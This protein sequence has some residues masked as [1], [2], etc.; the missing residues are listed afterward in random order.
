M[1]DV[2]YPRPASFITATLIAAL[3]VAL[4]ATVIGT[5]AGPFVIDRM[6]PMDEHA[7]PIATPPPQASAGPTNQT[8]PAPLY[9]PAPSAQPVEPA[10]IG[11]QPGLPPSPERDE[12]SS[13]YGTRGAD[14]PVEPAGIGIQPGRLPGLEGN[15]PS[16][17]YGTR[18]PG[19]KH[20]GFEAPPQ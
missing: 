14:Q 16:W 5:R 9:V 11:I 17:P 2:T 20:P 12:P 3:A 4:L 1:D 13:P 8:L 18:G 15:E 19:G 7:A 6:F 10:R